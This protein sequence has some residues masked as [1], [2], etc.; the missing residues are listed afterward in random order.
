ML[1]ADMQMLCRVKH[2]LF[3]NS[4]VSD[5]T[6]KRWE[7]R[8]GLC[9]DP[10]PDSCRPNGKQT[11]FNFKQSCIILGYIVWKITNILYRRKLIP[12]NKNIPSIEPMEIEFRAA[13]FNPQMP[14]QYNGAHSCKCL[15]G[16]FLIWYMKWIETSSTY[17]AC[18][19]KQTLSGSSRLN[20]VWIHHFTS[21]IPNWIHQIAEMYLVHWWRQFSS[22]L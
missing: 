22:G 18:N 7:K 5:V 20:E 15:R 3:S 9:P 12:C 14:W 13:E 2:G 21:R 4:S 6:F 17:A 19:Q 1:L 8:V 16:Y 11:L 10:D